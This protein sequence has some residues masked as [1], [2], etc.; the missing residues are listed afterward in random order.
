MD[1]KDLLNDG[2]ASWKENEERGSLTCLYAAVIIEDEESLP[3]YL[4]PPHYFYLHLTDYYLKI[5]IIPR[6]LTIL[7]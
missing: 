2:S 3:I 5:W 7:S 6:N 4:A 1:L